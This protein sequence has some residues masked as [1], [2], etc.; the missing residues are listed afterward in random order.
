M[1]KNLHSDTIVVKIVHHN[2]NTKSIGDYLDKNIVDMLDTI[3]QFL[4]TEEHI[5]AITML[6]Y[7]LLDELQEEGKIYNFK[8]LCDERNNP[9][10]KSQLGLHTLSIR[11]WQV[12]CINLTRIEYTFKTNVGNNSTHNF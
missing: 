5:E 3:G 11:F 12:N 8:V 1:D 7:E 10:D 9:K 4:N 2:L 6:A